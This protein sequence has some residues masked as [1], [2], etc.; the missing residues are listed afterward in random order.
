M[1]MNLQNVTLKEFFKNLE[2]QTSFSVVYRDIILSENPDVVVS[3]SN[4]PLKD[5]LSQVLEKH[6]LS[7]KVSN[8]TIVIVKAEAQAPVKQ[9]KTKK[10]SGVITDETG[11]PVAGANIVVKGTT[12][13]TIS[14]MDGNFSLE[15]A[16]GEMLEISYIGFLPMEVKIDNKNTFDILMKEDAQGLDEVVVVGYGTVK[17]RDLTGAVASVNAAKISAVPTSTA[18]EALQGR[19]PGV[20]VSNANW[21]PGS[22]PNVMIRG[23]R[24]I[25]ASNDPLYVI[26]GVPVTGGIGEISPSDIESMEVLKDASATAIYG[27]RGANGVILITTKQGKSGKT[28]IDYNAVSYTHLTLPTIA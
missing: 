15:A 24:S 4:R 18:S 14:D 11:L 23:K 16:P 9:R 2:A 10:I 17:K 3:A 22:T 26:D 6:G 5:I 7:Y 27:A 13:G 25:T 1:S 21:S 8:K 20:V 28:Q 19:I 12:N